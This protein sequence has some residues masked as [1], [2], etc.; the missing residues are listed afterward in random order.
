MEWKHKSL[1]KSKE[2]RGRW[3][4][5]DNKGNEAEKGGINWKRQRHDRERK[6]DTERDSTPTREKNRD[7]ARNISSGSVWK[8]TLRFTT[9]KV[10]RMRIG[11]INLCGRPQHVWVLVQQKSESYFIDWVTILDKKKLQDDFQLSYNMLDFRLRVFRQKVKVVLSVSVSTT[12]NN[13]LGKCMHLFL[14]SFLCMNVCVRPDKPINPPA[15]KSWTAWCVIAASFPYCLSFF[16]CSAP[17]SVCLCVRVQYFWGDSNR[18][19]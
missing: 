4:T 18:R 14:H 10:R 1:T 12:Y 15:N 5:G 16:L 11:Q 3:W 13:G 7:G 19:V 8:G 17:A 6:K 2:E 9:N